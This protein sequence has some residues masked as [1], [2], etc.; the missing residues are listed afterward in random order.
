M[1]SKV[2]LHR[3]LIEHVGR[4]VLADQGAADLAIAAE[5]S[6]EDEDVVDL[7]RQLLQ[8]RVLGGDDDLAA[9]ILGEVGDE[10]VGVGHVELP[11]EG[12]NADDESR[13]V[14]VEV[15]VLDQQRPELLVVAE[16]G[17]EGDDEQGD[18]ARDS[19]QRLRRHVDLEHRARESEG[20]EEGSELGQQLLLLR[21]I[22]V[23]LRLLVVHGDVA[24]EGL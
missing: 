22:R 1:M 7:Q 5:L 20:V 12:G 21:R 9:D 4:E 24:E 16:D 6:E 18:E 8:L 23:R 10:L 19:L 14:E 2:S 11:Q 17:C 15:A 13:T 3:E